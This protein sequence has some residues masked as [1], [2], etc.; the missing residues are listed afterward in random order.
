MSIH[1]ST[2][3]SRSFIRFSAQNQLLADFTGLTIPAYIQRSES[4]AFADYV[5]P[6]R[7]VDDF[8]EQSFD[9]ALFE[10][11]A[12]T[13]FNPNR[14]PELYQP[15]DSKQAATAIETRVAED[16]V[17]TYKQIQRQRSCPIVQS[18]NSLLGG[19]EES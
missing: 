17:E 11:V 2:Y 15:C 4:N 8:Q 10:E 6:S 1:S 16:L 12:A 9:E 14:H 5:T 7:D 3:A 13:I 18:L 19:S